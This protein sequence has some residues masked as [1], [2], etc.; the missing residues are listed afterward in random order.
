MSILNVDAS[1]GTCDLAALQVVI[2]AILQAM[3]GNL[4]NTTHDACVV[5][6]R[7]STGLST[8]EPDSRSSLC[9]KIIDDIVGEILNRCDGQCR[10]IGDRIETIGDLDVVATSV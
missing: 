7:M 4:M 8:E 10:P 5:E 1:G 6:H 2:D 9:Q 3:A